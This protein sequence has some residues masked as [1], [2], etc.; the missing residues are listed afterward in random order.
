QK[1]ASYLYW[2]AGDGQQFSAGNLIPLP[3]TITAIA[4]GAID[5]D[6][7]VQDTILGL[8]TNDGFQLVIYKGHPK[9]AFTQPEVYPFA[10]RIDVLEVGL[11]NQDAGN[12]LAILSAKKLW[13]L[14]G[15][16]KLTSMIER[17]PKII[18]L[19]FAVKTFVFGNFNPE[20]RNGL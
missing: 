13:V 14:M 4:V 2:I 20:S 19:R 18:R 8:Q 9:E 1:D 17:K 11:L 5:R 16:P 3:G 7:G 15:N 12:D 10:N 6:I